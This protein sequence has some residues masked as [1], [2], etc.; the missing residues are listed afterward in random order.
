MTFVN[1]KEYRV[2]KAK[3]GKWTCDRCLQPLF[4]IYRFDHF[5]HRFHPDP[6]EC[7]EALG[8]AVLRLMKRIETLE[9]VLKVT[10]ARLSVKELM[11]ELTR[12]D[13]PKRRPG[14]RP[15]PA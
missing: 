3:D 15:R 6:D 5:H 14:R 1:G 4:F 2:P 12:A 8:L 13:A 9:G 11:T 10:P 7:V